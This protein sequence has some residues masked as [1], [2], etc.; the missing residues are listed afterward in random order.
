MIGSI[1]PRRGTTG[2]GVPGTIGAGLFSCAS[3]ASIRIADDYACPPLAG[4][5]WP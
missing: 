3:Q 2:L 1:S 5:D 4:N